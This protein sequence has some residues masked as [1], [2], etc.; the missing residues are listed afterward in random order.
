MIKTNPPVNI[1]KLNFSDG[2]ILIIHFD[3]TNG[4]EY[5]IKKFRAACDIVFRGKGI[6]YMIIPNKGERLVNFEILSK[7]G[8][9]PID[10]LLKR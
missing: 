6:K 5:A 7:K 10:K 2:D 4:D 1:D 9:S 3:I 8:R